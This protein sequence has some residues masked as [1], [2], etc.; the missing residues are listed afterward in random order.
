MWVCFT[1]L[2]TICKFLLNQ[3][4]LVRTG[5]VSQPGCSNSTKIDMVW[6]LEVV[7]QIAEAE[8]VRSPL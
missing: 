2:Q 5:P 3:L 8:A 7:G 4:R 1:I 6:K